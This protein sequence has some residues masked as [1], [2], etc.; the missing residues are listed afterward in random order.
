MTVYILHNVHIETK[1]LRFYL[2]IYERYAYFIYNLTF[3]TYCTTCLR[4]YRKYKKYLNTSM[5]QY[6]Y[7]ELYRIL[8]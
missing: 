4:L 7:T 6:Y 8:I 3:H 2:V 1:Y 5:F